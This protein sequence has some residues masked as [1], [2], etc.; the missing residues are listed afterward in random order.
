MAS[1]GNGRPGWKWL[2]GFLAAAV[3]TGCASWGGYMVG[4]DN[5][6]D[7]RLTRVALRTSATEARISGLQSSFDAV[8]HQLNTIHLELTGMRQDIKDQWRRK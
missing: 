6:L 2:V 4:V 7:D 5:R 3:I 8:Q 1:N